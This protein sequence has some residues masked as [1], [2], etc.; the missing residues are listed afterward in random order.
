[1]KIDEKAIRIV[2]NDMPDGF[3]FEQFSQ[4]IFS[5]IFGDKFIPVGGSGDQG[6]DGFQ[7]VY[8]RGNF[9]KLIYQISTETVHWSQEVSKIT[10]T[11]DKLLKNGISLDKLSY[12][13]NRKVERK[14]TIQDNFYSK[15]EISLTIYDIDWFVSN[16]L[17][18]P[19]IADIYTTFVQANVHEY[20]K[21]TKLVEVGEF[22]T[23]PRL[24]VFLTQHVED[25]GNEK[26]EDSVLDGLILYSLEGTS[27]NE[28]LFKQKKE[29]ANQIKTLT[30][31]SLPDMDS[32]LESR[33]KF[34]SGK[35]YQKINHHTKDNTYCLPH[36]T[37]LELAE[38]DIKNTQ[39]RKDFKKDSL[40]ILNINFKLLEVKITELF[41]LFEEIIH[42]IYHK[43]GL[44]FSDFI[45]NGVNKEAIDDTLRMIVGRIIDDSSKKIKNKEKIKTALLISLREIAYNGTDSQREYLRKLSK[46]YMMVFLTQNDPK[47]TLFFK[48]LANK[49]DVFV[50]TSIIV[51]ALSEYYL[52]DENRRFW[53]LL[54]GAK[55]SG[56]TLK[57]NE[58][59]IDELVSH[60]KSIYNK[61]KLLYENNESD[62]LEDDITLLYI[63]EIIIRAY[64]Y[65]KKR[66]HVT[67]FD[68]FLMKFIDPDLTSIKEDL[69]LFLKEE[70]EIDYITTASQNAIL[71]PQEVSDL[72]EHLKTK[73]KNNIKKTEADAKLILHIYK[74]RELNNESD[75]SG[76]FGYKTWWLSQDVNTF[77]SVKEVFPDKYTVSC[78]M[79]SDFMYKYISLSPHSN[80]V[81]SLYKKCFPSL[82]GV[83]LSYHIPQGVSEYVSQKIT[84]HKD[85]NPTI[86]KRTLKRLTVKLMTSIDSLSSREF[87]SHFD[88]E[89]DSITEGHIINK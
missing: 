89:M 53:N 63:D 18:D 85:T 42:T 8:S 27:S 49:L 1:M 75:S 10:T 29:V 30:K 55:M 82:L 37:I 23:D 74:L 35:P 43:Q 57:I 21:P 60:F 31:F 81:D 70:F 34:L 71:D 67:N 40:E 20:Q 87:K 48:T 13:T 59:V 41:D 33:L 9:S 72:V 58:F 52:K 4:K 62:Y 65:A 84:E 3:I 66:N 6:I 25:G 39:L 44:E 46:T 2:L 17:S 7:N 32:R 14:D 26:I 86:V 15:Y 38:R 68:G 50:G 22:T 79:R 12:I 88:K 78:Y 69:I 83:N 45:I 47:I 19:R 11:Q 56:V 28:N 64:F 5:I 16:I 51:P 77:K 73:K 54:K 80:D 61:Y 76:I 24:Y 36:Q